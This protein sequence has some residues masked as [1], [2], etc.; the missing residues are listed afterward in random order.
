M[1]KARVP[2]VLDPFTITVD[3]Q[4]RGLVFSLVAVRTANRVMVQGAW[5]RS[6]RLPRSTLSDVSSDPIGG[7]GLLHRH[8][9]IGCWEVSKDKIWVAYKRRALFYIVHND[10]GFQYNIWSSSSTNYSEVS[11]LLFSSLL[12]LIAMGDPIWNWY[13]CC[14]LFCRMSHNI[15]L[16]SAEFLQLLA[17]VQRSPSPEF[18]MDFFDQPV[19][20]NNIQ[21]DRGYF[22]IV[23]ISFIYSL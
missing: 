10:F 6:T 20:L 16:T 2:C 11:V 21:L 9:L 13:L 8:W 23:R 18:S 17:D 15:E 22:H 7:W 1:V 4:P 19:V 14:C 5:T 3:G 12:K